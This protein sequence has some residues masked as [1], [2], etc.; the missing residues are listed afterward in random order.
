MGAVCSEVDVGV[1][2]VVVVGLVRSPG[3]VVNA[4]E[5]SD[6]GVKGDVVAAVVAAASGSLVRVDRVSVT[7]MPCASRV[8]ST[9]T[10][11]P[12]LRPI[13]SLVNQQR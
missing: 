5:D 12:A 6:A 1:V 7:G 13:I 2:V 4:V 10:V 8:T 11:S 3:D 9:T